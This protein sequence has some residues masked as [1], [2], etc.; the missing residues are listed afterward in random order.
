MAKGGSQTFVTAWRKLLFSSY[1][2]FKNATRAPDRF[3]VP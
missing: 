2:P 1:Y 3:G